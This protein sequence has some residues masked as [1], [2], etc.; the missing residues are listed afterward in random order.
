MYI[1]T[2]TKVKS[3]FMGIV[4]LQISL[5]CVLISICSFLLEKYPET[6]FHLNRRC[7]NLPFGKDNTFMS[8][9]AYPPSAIF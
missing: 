3:H 1:Y 7:Q 4:F 2:F 9:P 6:C 5:V 8:F